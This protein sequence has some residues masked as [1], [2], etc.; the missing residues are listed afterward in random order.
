M[1]LPCDGDIVTETTC[2]CRIHQRDSALSRRTRQIV[3]LH[4]DTIRNGIAYEVLARSDKY[5]N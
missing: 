1:N 3:I 5:L 4:L 2:A